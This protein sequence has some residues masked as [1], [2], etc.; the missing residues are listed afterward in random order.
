VISEI[1]AGFCQRVSEI[2]SDKVTYV[3][4]KVG[5]S[6]R[7]AD[8]VISGIQIIDA[9]QLCDELQGRL[10][11]LRPEDDERIYVEAMVK[12]STSCFDCL[13]LKPSD[14]EDEDEFAGDLGGDPMAASFAALS[15]VVERLAINA[16][17][18]ASQSHERLLAALESI[19]SLQAM[20][21]EAETRLEYAGEEKQRGAMGEAADIFGPLVPLVVEKLTG[22]KA[23]RTVVE[24]GI[25]PQPILL[26]R[27]VHPAA[28]K[29]ADPIK[30]DKNAGDL[31]PGDP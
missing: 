14:L 13:H 30:S 2:E 25:E 5:K 16:D 28:I 3:R 6:R 20:A 10:M 29:A 22:K 26:K 19:L 23:V 15:G 9:G 4:I 24:K 27:A 31:S 21:I 12:G 7:R 17:L 8:V 18:R 1:L 11:S